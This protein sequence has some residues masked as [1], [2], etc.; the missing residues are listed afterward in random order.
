MVYVYSKKGC[1]SQIFIVP[2]CKTFK[3]RYF[4]DDTPNICKFIATFKI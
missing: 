3:K 2:L 1:E 4:F